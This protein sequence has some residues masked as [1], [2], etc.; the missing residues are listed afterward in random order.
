MYCCLDGSVATKNDLLCSDRVSFLQI[1]P[2]LTAKC[3]NHT[4]DRESNLNEP[5]VIV[6]QLWPMS[7]TLA[8]HNRAF[9]I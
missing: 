9:Q 1:N 2:D 4:S 8:V 7:K 6:D 5:S 3:N